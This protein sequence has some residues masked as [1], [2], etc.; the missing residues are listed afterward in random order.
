VPSLS[1]TQRTFARAFTDPRGV[2][3]VLSGPEGGLLR[4]S[5]VDAPPLP[6]RLRLAVYA[7]GYFWRLLES[8][9]ADFRAVKTVL[10]DEDFQRLIADY[11]LENPSAS[12]RINDLGGRLPGFLKTHASARRLPFLP[13]LAALEWA[14]LQALLTDRLPPLDPAALS[15]VSE[16]DWPRARLTLDATVTLLDLSWP[17]ERLWRSARRGNKVRAPAKAV[18]QF[19]LVWRHDDGSQVR[20]LPR[21][22]FS[23]LLKIA[24]GQS[25][26]D[27]CNAL[28]AG[29]PL[30][31][32]FAAW[33]RD[34]VLKKVEI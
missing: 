16:D 32:W 1:E 18:P 31:A 30:Q 20:V 29:I 3:P 25:L 10:G 34:G 27:I 12:P 23:A 14:V 13:D 21:L 15:A 28:P 5:A 22:E 6:L 2:D 7:D 17:V 24:Q 4:A 8:L 19:L 26:G 9:G 11:L 33:T